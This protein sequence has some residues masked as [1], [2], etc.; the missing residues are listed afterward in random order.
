[1]PPNVR[2]HAD[3]IGNLH[4]DVQAAA[5]AAPA[6]ASAARAARIQ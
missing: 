6:T 5:P 4:L 1:V 2:V 3:A